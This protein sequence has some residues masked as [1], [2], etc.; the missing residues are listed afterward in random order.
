MLR[1]YPL[2][3]PPPL[4]PLDG[5]WEGPEVAVVS[6]RRA[7][8]DGEAVRFGGALRLEDLGAWDVAHDRKLLALEEPIFLWEVAG[9]AALRI[10][11]TLIVGAGDLHAERSGDGTRLWIGSEGDR[12]EFLVGVDRGTLEAH[13]TARGVRLVAT[14][15]R[16]LRLIVIGSAGESDRDRTLR[17][18]SRK[19]LSG[20]IAQRQQ[21]LAQIEGLRLRWHSPDPATDAGMARMAVGLDLAIE[22]TSDGR[23]TVPNAFE[24]GVLLLTFGLREQV[25]DLLRGSEDRLAEV[26]LFAAYA[27]WVGD[28]DFLRKQWPRFERTVRE[29]LV[30][31]ERAQGAALLHPIAEALGD[32]GAAAAL[33]GAMALLAPD[34]ERLLAGVPGPLAT[35]MFLRPMALEGTLH[36]SGGLPKEWPEMTFERLRVGA[37]TLDLRVRRR[38]AGLA[39]KCRRTHGPALVVRLRPRLDFTPTG[40]LVD[41]HQF[42]GSEVALTVT[43]EIEALWLT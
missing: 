6:G 24:D 32:A 10:E 14:G 42:G 20:L 36:W 13:E 29:R 9:P 12:A 34:V 22:E 16:K 35:A 43:D 17:S 8:L 3:P 7:R 31:E 23:R 5:D 33:E 21:H 18:L 38:P 30:G 11:G 1:P 25:R 41:E 37:S 19:G 15:E 26:G 40:I 39:V 4:P 27:A 28:D 2:E